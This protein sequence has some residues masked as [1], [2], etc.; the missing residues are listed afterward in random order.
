MID[1]GVEPEAWTVETKAP[2]L[3]NYGA[4]DFALVQYKRLVYLFGGKTGKADGTTGFSN[5]V[6]VYDLDG[7]RSN[8]MISC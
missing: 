4:K 7:D 5:Q 6:H 3:H 1:I 2:M 8:L